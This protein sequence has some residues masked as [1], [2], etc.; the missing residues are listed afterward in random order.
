M[1][2][3]VGG[4]ATHLNAPS[5][6]AGAIAGATAGAGT[7]TL[8]HFASSASSLSTPAGIIG[9][10]GSSG[11]ILGAI[12]SNTVIGA[13][14][15]GLTAAL[16]SSA[17]TTAV[18]M[19]GPIGKVVVGVDQTED[20]TC[21]FDCWKPIVHE[22]SK[23]PSTGRMLEEIAADPRTKMMTMEVPNSSLELPLVVIENIWGEKF[24]LEFV[25]AFEKVYAHAVWMK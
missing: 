15:G 7:F 8:A 13:C 14:A 9:A 1:L 18:S 16:S 22:W 6:I 24:K 17:L 10:S 4:V 19:L 20:G 25:E 3:I 23:E 2:V 5:T 21:T 11:A 12:T